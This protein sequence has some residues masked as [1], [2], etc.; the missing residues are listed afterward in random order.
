LPAHGQARMAEEKQLTLGSYL[1]A[2][3]DV[4]GQREKFRQLRL[5]KTPQE[6]TTVQ[7]VLTDTVGFVFSL[8][9]VFQKNFE[10]FKEGLVS[11]PSTV[12]ANSTPDFMGFSDSFIAFVALRS[13][14]EHL[15]PNVRIY[16]ALSA[17]SIVM[18]TALAS[19]HALRGGIDVGLAAE[20]CPGEIY[21][22]ALERA[23]LLE[24]REAG[25]PRILI[26]D[27]LWNY[28]SIGIK[29][30]EKLTTPTARLLV[31]LIQRDMEFVT[32]D[33]DGKRILDY[34]GL[35]IIRISTAQ[36]TS[37][38]SAYQFVLEQHEHW[39]SEG[40]AQLSGR[41]AAL[42]RYFESRLPLWG[43]SAVKS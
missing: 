26:G 7:G 27:E 11:M 33:A 3:L 9:R 21:G 28:L 41:Y 15:T 24:C 4:L 40:N 5:P 37:V 25:Y 32:V 36:K 42:R 10:L 6:Y 2:F 35:G 14:D 20:M 34:L 38:E 16:S 22:T 30:F 12:K 17:A 13:E 39:L 23:Y 18:V 1:V 19:K 43:L 31:K 29:E 8:R